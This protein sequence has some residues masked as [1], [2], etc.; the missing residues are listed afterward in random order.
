MRDQIAEQLAQL[1]A[2]GGIELLVAR[3]LVDHPLDRLVRCEPTC[4]DVGGDRVERARLCGARDLG[5]LIGR[6]Q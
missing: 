4:G 6:I 5:G 2:I 1:G 3:D